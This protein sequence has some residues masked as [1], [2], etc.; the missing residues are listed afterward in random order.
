MGKEAKQKHHFLKPDFSKA[1]DKVG[2]DFMIIDLERIGM[3]IVF[4]NMI[5]FLFQNLEVP[6]NL[7]EI[8]CVTNPFLLHRGVRQGFP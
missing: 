4:V 7:F 3:P 2:W 1:Y 8:K 5:R 6:V